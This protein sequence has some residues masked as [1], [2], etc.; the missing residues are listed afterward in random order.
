MAVLS[1]GPSAVASHATAC[2][3]WGMA[4]RPNQIEV[5]ITT[6]G[7][8]TRDHIIH[9]TTDLV[10]IDTTVVNGLGCTTLAR[11]LVD[12]GVPWGQ[13]FVARCLDEALRR[14]LVTVQAVAA[15]L[16]GVARKGRNGVGPMRYVLLERVG[17]LE[18]S[19]GI[20]EDEFLRIMKAA[21]VDLPAPQVELYRRGGRL[22]A[23]VDFV[24]HQFR[25]VIELDGEAFHSDR[26]SFRKDR[27]KQNALVL[28]GYRV[29]R[30]TYFDLFAA[31]E[32]VVSQ[33]VRAI[34]QSR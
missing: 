33:V 10:D 12:V 1:F 11:S 9:R 23:R 16:H 21:G 7:I 18:L 13:G 26:D 17:A 24:Y 32:Y 25:L 5:S 34:A 28:E 14:R 22:I 8:P 15:V 30:F 29:L 20:M 6:K 3:L 31:S 4:R 19:E 2:H 27:R